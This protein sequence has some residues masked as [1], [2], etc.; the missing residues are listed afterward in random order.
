MLASTLSWPPTARVQ[1]PGCLKHNSVS[2]RNSIQQDVQQH[3]TSASCVALAYA[4][5]SA[6]MTSAPALHPPFALQCDI[7]TEITFVDGLGNVHVVPRHS[8]AGRG[9][10]SGLGLLGII[11]ELKLQMGVSKSGCS[12][13]SSHQTVRQTICM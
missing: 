12:T 1:G 2:A 7:V 9:L 3:S 11:T 5:A 8:A 4:V 13:S 10:C 6:C